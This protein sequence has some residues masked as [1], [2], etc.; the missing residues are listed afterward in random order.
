MVTLDEIR[1]PEATALYPSSVLEGCETALV[2][3]AAG[4]YGRQDCVAIEEAGLRATCVDTDHEKLGA[5][6]MAY[7][8]GWE[9]VHGDAYEYARLTERTWDVVSL[10]PFTNQM[11][12]CATRLPLWCALAR[13][14]VVLGSDGRTS[15]IVPNG[16]TV[17]GEYPRSAFNGGTYWTVIERV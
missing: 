10:D 16:W 9:F 17:A 15:F 3:F 14:A 12:E 13:R 4:F 7:P 6:T 1:S 8:A 11:Q 2:L 5:M